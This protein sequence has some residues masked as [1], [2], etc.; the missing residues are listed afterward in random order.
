MVGIRGL[1]VR[2]LDA[3]GKPSREYETRYDD[4]RAI[5]SCYV[6]SEANEVSGR[7]SWYTIILLLTSLTWRLRSIAVQYRV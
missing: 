4:R 3:E 2:L 7:S 6:V 5:S 1:S